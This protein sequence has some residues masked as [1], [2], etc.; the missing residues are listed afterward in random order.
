MYP[1]SCNQI[2][3]ETRYFYIK[4]LTFRGVGGELMKCLLNMDLI[5][6]LPELYNNQAT[7][8]Y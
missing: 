1:S 5:S 3:L 7:S 2:I 6:D 4:S 8:E